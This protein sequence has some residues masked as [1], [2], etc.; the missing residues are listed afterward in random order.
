MT[1][2]TLHCQR[3]NHDWSR[4]PTRGRM[5]TNCPEHSVETPTAASLHCTNGDHDWSFLGAG[6]RPASCPDHQ[7]EIETERI[8]WCAV[9][10][11]W[12][13]LP[14][15]GRLPK[16]CPD[17]LESMTEGEIRRKQDE[18]R[19]EAGQR[20]AEQLVIAMTGLQSRERSVI[21]R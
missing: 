13:R 16:F 10:H 14:K 19:R 11:E 20:R 12:L 17:H 7:A 9:G 21:E 1:A 18:L 2:Q 3:G 6:R 8:L 5:P 4:E 15:Q